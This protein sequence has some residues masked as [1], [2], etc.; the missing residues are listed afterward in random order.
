MGVLRLVIQM[1]VRD[2]VVKMEGSVLGALVVGLV[3]LQ[4]ALGNLLRWVIGNRKDIS[5]STCCN[6]CCIF[7]GWKIYK[8][9]KCYRTFEIL[10]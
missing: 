10:A 9:W 7:M 1:V 8:S 4:E 2:E 3:I 6:S 5:S